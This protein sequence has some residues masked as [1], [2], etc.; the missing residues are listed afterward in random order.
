[1]I[2]EAD[3]IIEQADSMSASPEDED[4]MLKDMLR[5]LIQHL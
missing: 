3:N 4:S 2:C 5:T 1:M